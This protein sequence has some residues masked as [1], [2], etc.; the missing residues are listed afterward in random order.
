MNL[1]V[2]IGSFFTLLLIVIPKTYCQVCDFS[3]Y[4]IDTIINSSVGIYLTRSLLTKTCQLF[5]EKSME[6]VGKSNSC[7]GKHNCDILCE[8]MIN[9]YIDEFIFIMTNT[10][11]SPYQVC[12]SIKMCPT[13][14]NT[15]Y[16]IPN[17]TLIKSNTTN[18]QNEPRFKNWNLTTGIGKFIQ[19]TDVH[20]DLNY[21]SGYEANCGLPICCNPN[22][23]NS[24]LSIKSGVWGSPMGKCDIPLKL[25]KSLLEFVHD[26]IEIDGIFYTGDGPPHDI[27]KQSRRY[28]LN[29]NRIIT[30]LINYNLP[31]I[32]ISPIIGNHDTFPLNQEPGL[33]KS[34]WLYNN[35]AYNWKKYFSEDSHKTFTFGGFYTQRL[36]PGLRVIGLNTNVYP[37]ENWWQSLYNHDDYG[38]QF[39]W[40]IDV[41]KQSRRNVEKIII[42]AHHSPN[43]WYNNDFIQY[44]ND[45]LIEYSDIIEISIYG[46]EHTGPGIRLYFD[47]NN[48]TKS[49]GIVGGSVTT[50]TELNPAFT[51]YTY[52]RTT[53]EIIDFEIWWT[54]LIQNPENPNWVHQYNFLERHG[55]K[56]F[57]PS[58]INSFAN[59]LKNNKTIY[60]NYKQD[61]YRNVEQ[62]NGGK[63]QIELY[64]EIISLNQEEYK[65]CLSN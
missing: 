58:S 21:K 1:F 34:S 47:K 41:L 38:H 64:C 48:Q 24:K 36:R 43:N 59:Q 9:E 12:S 25:L 14:N 19:I 49:I 55:I 53:N 37:Q 35:L 10:K 45:I 4:H 40:L 32:S 33:N 16:V 22:Y 31:N 46:H 2:L 15:P 27:W 62:T 50:Y 42:L 61:Y 8:G 60:T 11:L 52:N 13:K 63:S 7:Q 65:A 57:T 3:V 29:I 5:P 20:L 56:E 23:S 44:Y 30:N 54:D 51:V 26:N 6:I 18:Y 39:A 17:T 28:N